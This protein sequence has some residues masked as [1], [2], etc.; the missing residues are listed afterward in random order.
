MQHGGKL[1]LGM[2]KRGQQALHA[3]KR[4]ID[5]LGVKLLKP[6]KQGVARCAP[7]SRRASPGAVRYLCQSLVPLDAVRQIRIC[8]I[9]GAA[10]QVLVILGL[11]DGCGVEAVAGVRN[12][13]G[14]G[15]MRM[16]AV[17]GLREG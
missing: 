1:L 13:R 11:L 14:R 12:G 4:Q 15:S 7:G 17:H 3:P 5:R 10:G 2:S 16:L 8:A 9:T 6:L